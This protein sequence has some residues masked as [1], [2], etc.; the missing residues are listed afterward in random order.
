MTERDKVQLKHGKHETKLPPIDRSRPLAAV[1][2]GATA[3]ALSPLIVP[4]TGDAATLSTI[5]TFNGAN[6]AYPYGG[7][8][9]DSAGNLFGTTHGDIF[10][11]KGSVFELAKG[12]GGYTLS[13]IATFN[14][15]N[16]AYPRA[17][18][19]ADNVGNLFGSTSSGGPTDRGTLFEL[20]KSS[21]GYTL[22][23]LAILDGSNGISPYPV[24]IADNA[25]NLFGTANSF[26]A[27]G[28]GT[29]FELAKGS[30]G[31]TL[32]T[33]VAFNGTNG[34]YPVSGLTADSAGNLFGTTYSGGANDKGTV[35]KLVKGSEGYTL[36]T[37]ATFNGING[38]RPSG[39]VVAD[40]VGNLFGTT[41]S[42]GAN[43]K[44]VVFELAK[45]SGGYTLSTIATFNGSNGAAPYAGLLADSAGNLFGTTYSGG[46]GGLGTVFELVKG[47]EG[48]TLSTIATFDGTG[49][50]GAN[51]YASLVADSAGNLFGVAVNAGAGGYGT[52]FQITGS[53]FVPY[54]TQVPAPA[55]LGLFGMGL[56]ALGLA[57]RYRAARQ[58]AAAEFLED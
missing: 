20:A 16:G 49:T 7:L 48:Y 56:L 26:G 24:L 50:N 35:F 54:A 38:A 3:L 23:T 51:P 43:N 40:S 13:T 14:G 58:L 17:G 52:V 36:S 1:L 22:S 28:K 45:G 11:T 10:N 18:L 5:A 4:E 47:S 6:G 19:L 55:G 27:G 29:V 42:G 12:S 32:S 33:I 9:V 31:Y 53:G 2:L 25:G 41:Y 15:S 37:I 21:G 39:N 44:G 46:S 8:M 30:E 34:G 57:R